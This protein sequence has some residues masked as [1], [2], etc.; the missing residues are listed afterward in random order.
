MLLTQIQVPADVPL[1]LN[2]FS[3]LILLGIFQGFFL[4]YFFLNKTNR[5]LQPNIFAGLFILALSLNI[6]EVFLNYTGFILKILWINDFSEPL[7]FVIGPFFFFY[8]KTSCQ[9]KI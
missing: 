9:Y 5:K 3:L 4:V 8:A 2:I 6:S 7:N 1:R